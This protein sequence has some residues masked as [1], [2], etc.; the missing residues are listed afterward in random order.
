ML[1]S[2]FT[3]HKNIYKL[4]FFKKTKKK[5]PATIGWSDPTG[6]SPLQFNGTDQSM[7]VNDLDIQLTDS[8][9]V[10][11]YPW[12]LDPTHP[13]NGAT[14]GNNTRDNVE[15]IEVDSANSGGYVLR[16]LHK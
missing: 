8:A 15:K 1:S 9:G 16:I 10:K 7:L 6:I 5:T 4:L 3:H 11:Y 2:P 12:I 14:K 13:S